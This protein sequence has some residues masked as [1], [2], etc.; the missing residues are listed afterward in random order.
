MITNI[1]QQS[2]K[3]TVLFPGSFDPFTIGHADI[4]RRSLRLFDRVVIGIGYNPNKTATV[5]IESRKKYI[6]ELYSDVPQV[7]VVA[8]HELTAL[9]AQKIG[10]CAIVKGVRW[11]RDYESEKEQA[12]I[13]QKLT[14]IETILLMAAPSMEAVSATMVRELAAFGHDVSDFLPDKADCTASARQS[15][16]NDAQ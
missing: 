8:Y 6:S 7:E 1:V 10:A 3:R 16:S 14:G 9:V 12:E 2:M 13:N 11:I 15:E 5:D 4:V